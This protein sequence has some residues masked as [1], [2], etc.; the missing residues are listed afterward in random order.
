LAVDIKAVTSE[1]RYKVI[2][3][4]LAAGFTRIG[5]AKTFIHADTDPDKPANLTW[6]Y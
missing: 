2:S 3:A 1:T 6:V 5:I 4:L